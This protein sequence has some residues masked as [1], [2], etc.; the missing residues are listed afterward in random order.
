MQIKV[1]DEV[2]NR[3]YTGVFFTNQTNHTEFI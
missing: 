1:L 2:L 3:K